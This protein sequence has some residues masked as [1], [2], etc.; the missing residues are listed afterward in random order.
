MTNK[1]KE[2]KQNTVE[3][4]KNL[5][6]TVVA[7]SLLSLGVFAA[8]QGH[9]ET[10]IAFYAYALLFAGAVNVIVGLIAF[11]RALMHKEA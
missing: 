5:A 11:Y 10:K 1:A 3:F 7:L 2:V 9:Y 8:Y 6:H 4:S